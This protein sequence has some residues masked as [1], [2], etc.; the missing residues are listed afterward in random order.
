[1]F[2]V[3]GTGLGQA[4]GAGTGEQEAQVDSTRLRVLETLRRLDRPPISDSIVLLADSLAR[5]GDTLAIP[6]E[7][8]PFERERRGG[9]E[10]LSQPQNVES[11]NMEDFLVTLPGYSLTEYDADR[12]EFNA[13]DRRL[14]LLGGESKGVQVRREGMVLTAD[15]SITYD[16]ARSRVLAQ[17]DSVVL[18]PPE[19]GDP[20]ASKLLVY[21]L[22]EG[23]GSARSAQT[24][25]RES[26][27]WKVT[28][29]LPYLA[30]NIAYANHARFTS[31]DLEIPHYH[32]ETDE[33]KIVGDGVLVAR[34]VRLYF[35]DVPVAWLPFVA[36]SLGDGRASGL[37]T[38]RFSVNDIA[39]TS[40]SYNRR[41]SNVGFYWAINDY[42]DTS[43][44][45]DWFSN[46]YTSLTGTYQYR[47]LAKFLQ[48][49]LNLRRYW[50]EEGGRELAL[51]TRHSWQPDE[52][53]QVRV[54]GRYASSLSFVRRNTFDPREVTQ[55]IDS[56]GGV[57]RRFDWGSMAF[58]ANRRQYLS[59]D[60]VEMTLPQV[61]LSLQPITIFAAPGSDARWYNNW[62]W[63]GS[64]NFSRRTVDRPP[65]ADSIDTPGISLFDQATNQGGINSGFAF[66][67]LSWSQSLQ[68][69][70]N[71]VKDF[72]SLPDSGD[73]V[74]DAYA[75]GLGIHDGV[76]N[77]LMR[78]AAVAA[79]MGGGELQDLARADVSWGSSLGY[80]QRLVGTTTL[81]PRLSVSGNLLR[82]DQSSAVEAR[83]GFVSAPARVSFG[84]SL[85]SDLY[86]FWPGFGRYSAVRHKFSPTF[87][88]SYS[89]AVS[90]DSLQREVFN[91]RDLRAQN[92]LSIGLNQTFE[93]KVQESDSASASEAVSSGSGPRRMQQ[94]Q[95][96]S[97]L[98]IRT[99]AVTYDFQQADSLGDWTRGFADNLTISN[100]ISS[101]FLRGLNFSFETDVFNS[102]VSEGQTD[103]SFEPHVSRMNLSFS[104]GSRSGVFQWLSRVTGGEGDPE[105][106]LRPE[107]ETDEI[108]AEEEALRDP[109]L[110]PDESS[111]LPGVGNASF[112]GSSRANRQ[113]GR[114]DGSVGSWNANLSYS[115]VRP[116]NSTVESQ[117]MIQANVRFKP[118]E[119]WD[120]TWQT[121]FDVAAGGFN[122]HILRLTRDLHRWEA[123]FDFRQTATGNWTFRFEVS[124]LD[125][126]DLKFD[127]KQQDLVDGL[128][129]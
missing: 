64:T 25:Y 99:S 112:A 33:L 12:A 68:F 45:A 67:P 72:P 79:L 23:R 50:R 58:T 94:A 47:W 100:Q 18:V 98:A 44:A 116:R 8:R 117:Q 38:P 21:D 43:L 34:P 16:E 63:T 20:V 113:S 66:G 81:T 13:V 55:S 125:N 52:R 28:G 89:P 62:T 59:D 71:V 22:E 85:K 93:A 40:S 1:V 124:L 54:S 36:Q 122:D 109:T 30:D 92:V 57:N 9:G 26:G 42:M 83:D 104:L 101:D 61:T 53:T 10:R 41:I 126:R 74:G 82:D 73:I 80:Q 119:R 60:R 5:V 86:G 128:A 56:E 46:N 114:S 120:V 84:A 75:G 76:G 27:N 39:R 70:E 15:S 87:D 110:G 4:A 35:S 37:L 118:T 31:C 11:A 24:Q 7:L 32:F 127:Y 95:T 2:C 3:P 88:Y 48:G 121:S 107:D 96:V 123:A 103:R 78:P 102:T 111:I 19:G 108:L 90:P 106:L 69:T 49:N 17:G 14:F 115:L 51:D 65:V 77:P 91:A 6:E 129:R 105:G 29:D 97:L